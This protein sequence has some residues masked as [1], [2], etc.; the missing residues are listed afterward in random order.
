MFACTNLGILLQDGI[1]GPRELKEAHDLQRRACEAGRP[2]GC[3]NWG[4][5]F[6]DGLFVARDFARAFQI[7]DVIARREN[8]VAPGEAW[9]GGMKCTDSGF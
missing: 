4:T 8:N 3:S 2:M 7:F 9:K 1:G 5:M 6:L